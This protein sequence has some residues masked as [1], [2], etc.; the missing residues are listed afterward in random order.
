MNRTSPTL[1]T[2]FKRNDPKFS[3]FLSFISWQMLTKTCVG[4]SRAVFSAVSPCEKAEL[5]EEKA[6]GRSQSPFQCP[7]GLQGS[8]R[9]TCDKDMEWQDTGNGS[10]WRRAGTDGILGG[11]SSL[12]QGETLALNALRDGGCSPPSLGLFKARLKQALSKL[13]WWK[14]GQGCW[15]GLD[16]F[17]APSQPKA[18]HNSTA[19]PWNMQVA[20]FNIGDTSQRPAQGETQFMTKELLTS[21]FAVVNVQKNFCK[22]LFPVKLPLHC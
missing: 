8:W 20:V 1:S 4:R 12:W 21:V 18:L 6:L 13:G 3:V 19:V 22:I 2:C 5:W 17:S 9:G 7:K 16:D 14:L 10:D 15:K 11:N